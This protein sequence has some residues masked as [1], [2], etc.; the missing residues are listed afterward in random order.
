HSRQTRRQSPP[1]P[2]IGHRGRDG[3][4]GLLSGG[5]PES[6]DEYG[7]GQSEA[8]GGLFPD[9]EGNTEDRPERTMSVRQQQEIQEVL[10]RMNAQDCTFLRPSCQRLLRR[11]FA[12]YAILGRLGAQRLRIQFG[13]PEEGS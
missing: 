7:P 13:L 3:M 12:W 11:C 9:Q 5:Q 1:T 6:R 8:S 4:V 10:R 2:C